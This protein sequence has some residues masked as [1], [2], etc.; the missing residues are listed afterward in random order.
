M[1]LAHV[2]AE[3]AVLD[4]GVVAD[5][6]ARPDVRARPEVAERPDRDVV[7]DRRAL[8]DAGPDDAVGADRA[9]DDL[10]P[11]GD[12]ASARRSAS[13][14]GARRS[15]RGRRPRRAPRR[16]RGRPWR[17]PTIVT[18]ARIQR[19]FTSTRMSHSARASCARSLMPVRRPSSSTSSAATSRPSS[20][21]KRTRSVTYSSP[22]TGEGSQV[23]DPAPE[24]RRL[25]R[26]QAGVDLA[27][28]RAPRPVASLSST[29]RSTVPPSL[30]TT[31]PSPV[32]SI[33]STLTSA[34]AAWSMP[35]ASSSAVRQL[36]PHQGHVPVEHEHLVDV[37]V[38]RPRAPRAARRRCRAGRPGGRRRRAVATASRTASVA[39]RVDHQR[40][41]RRS[42]ATAASST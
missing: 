4:L 32:G 7:L 10:R 24:P 11:G 2:L 3:A 36:G 5:L 14:P 41:R 17:G 13:R 35:R 27:D 38:E 37:V 28:R 29:I 33:A 9:V 39:G 23:A 26:V 31:R 40:P 34:T 1:V 16:G 22:L 19:S 12:R 8:D 15:A 6:R 25:D 18:P 21:A 30:R 42:T 20:R